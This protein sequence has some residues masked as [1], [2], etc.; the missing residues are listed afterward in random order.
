[1]R[2]LIDECIDER[3]RNALSHHECQTARYAGFGSVVRC[4]YAHWYG[5]AE[6]RQ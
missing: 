1:M 4:R 6:G 2:V 5:S 3:F